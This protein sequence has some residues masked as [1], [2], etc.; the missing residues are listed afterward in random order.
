LCGSNG[1][2]TGDGLQWQI[3]NLPLYI[4][5]NKWLIYLPLQVSRK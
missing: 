1:G 2:K 3:H 5:Q 4:L